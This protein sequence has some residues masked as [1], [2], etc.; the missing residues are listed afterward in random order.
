MGE[1]EGMTILYFDLDLGA[2]FSQSCNQ[3]GLI[4]PQQHVNLFLLS[5]Q[6]TAV[7]LGLDRY[8]NCK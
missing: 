2:Q 6:I 1:T 7:A 5:M 4:I 8:M 3:I